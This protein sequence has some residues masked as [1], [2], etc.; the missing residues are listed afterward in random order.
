MRGHEG[1][2]S[3]RR[4]CPKRMRGIDSVTLLKS[5]S[6]VLRLIS[7]SWFLASRIKIQCDGEFVL[8]LPGLDLPCLA[9]PCLALPCPD[10][11]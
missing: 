11:P 9:L 7:V 1:A 5:Y 4:E 2:Q 10:L 3:S 6:D 8:F